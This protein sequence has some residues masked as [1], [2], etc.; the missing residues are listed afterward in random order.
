[1]ETL[2]ENMRGRETAER[3]NESR[4]HEAAGNGDGTGQQDSE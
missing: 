1:M 3:L 2:E 4:T